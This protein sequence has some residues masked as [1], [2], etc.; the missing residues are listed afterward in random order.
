MAIFRQLSAGMVPT[1]RYDVTLMKGLST[2]IVLFCSGLP[3]L[4]ASTNP[5]S[6]QLLITAKQQASLFHN[7]SSPFQLDVG[8]VTQMNVPTQGHLS[9]KWNKEN[10][11]WRKIVMGGFEQ[12]EVRNGDKLYISRNIDF[13]PTR[14]GELISLLAFA[15]GSEGLLVKNQKQ[16]VESGV[17]MVCL[18]IEGESR[19]RN[20][21]VCVNSVHEILSDE[22]QE[23]PDEKRREQYSDYFTFEGHRY[24]RKL[25]LFINGIQVITATV[26]DLTSAAFDES[27]LVPPTGAI[28]RRKCT[29]MKHA[30]PVKTP[31]PMYPKSAS[32]NKMMGDTTVAM[33]VL[34]DGSVTDIHLIGSAARSMDEATLQ[35]LKGWRFKPAM[36]GAE[37]VVSDI[38]VIVSFRLY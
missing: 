2:A 22:W 36:C 6:Q 5:A 29:D 33:T 19:G 11:W 3:L 20:H 7:Q 27:L 21:D 24:P 14:I 1:V 13:S 34:T 9:L 10:Q 31:D 12:V 23:P 28:E 4:L 17:E 15:E 37:P 25:Q 38:Q 8:F 35:T 32:E 16:R 30:I 18:R 26:D